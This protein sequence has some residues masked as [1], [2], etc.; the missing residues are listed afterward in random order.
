MPPHPSATPLVP[1]SHSSEPRRPLPG[2]HLVLAGCLT[3]FGASGCTGSET[4]ADSTH[5]DSAGARV[6]ASAA[7]ARLLTVQATDYAYVSLADSVSAGPTR[8]ALENRGKQ[9]HE[10]ALARLR[11]GVST[12]AAMEV[13]RSGGDP[14]GVIDTTFGILV[15][16]PGATS[17][18]TLDVLL[19]GGRVYA[20]VCFLRDAPTQPEHVALGMFASFVARP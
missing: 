2:V 15:A 8:I 9:R 1:R 18:D 10:L 3:A 4:G 5:A 20:I 6:T 16:A 12:S 7:P 14:A 13:A 19:E 17:A 11:P